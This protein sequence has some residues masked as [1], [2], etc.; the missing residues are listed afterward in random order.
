MSRTFRDVLELDSGTGGDALWKIIS[1][2]AAI[3][4]YW[5]GTRWMKHIVGNRYMIRFAFPAKGYVDCLY[6]TT[7]MTVRETYIKGPFK[8]EKRISVVQGNGN[9]V[10][11]VEWD[12]QYS[13]PFFMFASMMR[14]HMSE[15]TRNAMGRIVEAAAKADPS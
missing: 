14:K 1:N 11:K 2:T 7:T 3:P 13:F 5:H 10:L 12:I 8:G 4:K 15:G 6:N 9:A